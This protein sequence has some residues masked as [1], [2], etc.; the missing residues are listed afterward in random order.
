MKLEY[1]SLAK[2]DDPI[3]LSK[4]EK[5][6]KELDEQAML[7]VRHM[8]ICNHKGIDLTLPCFLQPEDPAFVMP[9]KKTVKQ[10]IELMLALNPSWSKDNISHML[11]I[12]TTGSNRL[13]NYWLNESSERQINKS[14]WFLLAS[15]AGLLFLTVS[16]A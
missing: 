2:L 10:V 3:F 11:G 12:S 8:L 7:Q 15:K 1:Y 14:N 4:F 6:K 9:D 5:Q 16:K 13:L